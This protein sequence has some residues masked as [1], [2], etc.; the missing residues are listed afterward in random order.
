MKFLAF[1]LIFFS[2]ASCGPKREI[3][4]EE[5][6]SLRAEAQN[7]FLS[8]MVF[9]PGGDEKKI[10][11]YGG[12]WNTAMD[13]DPT[14]FNLTRI[15]DLPTSTIMSYLCPHL[16]EYDIHKKEWSGHL[17]DFEV[18]SD[19]KK[20]TT[21]VRFTFKNGV[22]WFV[23]KTGE[24]VPFNAD[25]A[26]FWIEEII[27]DPALNMAE[28][29]GMFV[30]MPD[31]S[32]D[33]I[34]AVKTGE[35]SFKLLFPRIVAD[36]LLASNL[37]IGP[38]FLYEAAKKRGGSRETVD[39]IT[40]NTDVQTIPTAGPFYIDRYT[41]GLVLILKRN[42]H[43]FLEDTAGQRLPYLDSIR[44]QFVSNP[45]TRL[46]LFQ[47]GEL[48]TLSV[49]PQDLDRI[50]SGRFDGAYEV[51]N[52]GAAPSAA[53]ITWNQN[54]DR[55]A[56]S[57][58]H[59]D[60]F[61]KKEFRQAMS[62]LLDREKIIANVYRGLAK[63]VTHFFNEASPVFEENIVFDYFY[64]PEKAIALLSSIGVKKDKF[65]TMRDSSGKAVQ[66]DFW[67]SADNPQL[68]DIANLYADELKKQGITMTI[69]TI[70]FAKMVDSLLYT[71]DWQSLSIGLSGS[72]LFPSQG[73]NV[74]Q[75][76]GNLHMWNPNQKTPATDWEAE[77]DR[78]YTEASHTADTAKAKALWDRYQSLIWEEVPLVYLVRPYSFLAV[79]NKWENVTF[80]ALDSFD[81]R[82]VFEKS[83]ENKGGR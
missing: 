16:L 26:V 23:P 66:F 59:F 55:R 44:F 13:S 62:C 10:G 35:T 18:I 47:N 41:P 1:F 53:F 81:I 79:H 61:S 71:F 65:G 67:I 78:L 54:P 4:S 24:T 25:D 42:P 45:S 38:R 37:Q 69:R 68:T 7:A 74:W 21:E 76:N 15:N 29:S 9:R 34:K 75:S 63:P 30:T 40:I 56:L 5:A 14:T 32:R 70:D 11:N 73:V 64:N 46:L 77:I 58:T 19:E 48:E 31:G 52:G 50:L 39:F 57:Q 51:I 72:N 8:Q 12:V 3:S 43:Y 20:N 60:L 27:K 28:Y 33:E 36:P 49:M 80:D 2:F 82:Y 17:A 83:W 22:T 6:E